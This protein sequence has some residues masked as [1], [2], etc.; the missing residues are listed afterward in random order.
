ML[1]A[2]FVSETPGVNGGSPVVAGTRTPVWMLLDYYNDLQD[3][4]EITRLLPHLSR[5]QVQGAL[6]YYTACP[7]RVDEDRARNERAWVELTG[8]PWPD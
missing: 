8:Q 2:R 5:E 3:V 6:D 1:V 7:D 4:E